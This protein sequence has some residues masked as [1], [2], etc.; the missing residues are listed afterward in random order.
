MLKIV[1]ALIAQCDKSPSLKV[2]RSE[3]EQL[4]RALIRDPVAADQA[5]RD[6]VLSIRPALRDKLPDP[7]V[8][9]PVPPAPSDGPHPG[10]ARLR[11]A[12]NLAQIPAEDVAKSN[13]PIPV[14]GGLPPVS[15]GPPLPDGKQ[16]PR[17]GAGQAKPPPQPVT[18][19][20]AAA[21]RP[22]GDTYLS[23][24]L[25]KMI[26]PDM[27]AA[28]AEQTGP[29]GDACT[30][31]N[32][33][34][35]SAS[36]QGVASAV[37]DAVMTYLRAKNSN[38]KPGR[39]G[40][41]DAKLVPALPEVAQAALNDILRKRAEAE[42]WAEFVPGAIPSVRE[43]LE[44]Q[45]AFK[46]RPAAPPNPDLMA[47]R[48]SDIGTA[49]LDKNKP[50]EA[51]MSPEAVAKSNRQLEEANSFIRFEII[52]KPGDDGKVRVKPVFADRPVRASAHGEDHVTIKRINAGRQEEGGGADFLSWADCHR[53]AQLIMGSEDQPGGVDDSER[54]VVGT[55][56]GKRA[57]QPLPRGAVQHIRK[58]KDS[59]AARALYG[60]LDACLP[61]F[62]GA[63]LAGKP[64]PGPAEQKV[65]D[66]LALADTVQQLKIEFDILNSRFTQIWKVVR[67]NKDLDA[68]I[69]DG[70]ETRMSK[71]VAAQVRIY[72]NVF[73]DDADYDAADV[74]RASAAI[75][76]LKRLVTLMEAESGLVFAG[77]DAPTV[78]VP[79]DMR[80][81]YMAI[82]EDPALMDAL[83]RELGLNQ[84]ARPAV[85]DAMCQLNDDIRKE[86]AEDEGRD[87]WNY[88]WAGVVMVND[89]GS[90]MAL[91]N[92]SVEDQRAVNEDWYFAL[93]R[94]DGDGSFHAVNC[95]D[96]HVV[97]N[98]T[99]MV[100]KRV[101]T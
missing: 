83:S 23:G 36:V 44:S 4:R 12:L 6:L 39:T 48:S 55:G 57:L 20:G 74:A 51:F 52:G 59:G 54:I 7:P 79:K 58:G 65:L 38:K 98:A 84:Y 76:E 50:K 66:E 53:T 37:Y 95:H 9:P 2:Y 68:G 8:R 32:Y 47:A 28:P 97:A 13:T 17:V 64:D 30:R 94:P 19:A 96:D 100:M 5:A 34:I 3:L 77:R 45:V 71:G 1:E 41:V 15:G 90:F 62:V 91:E 72:D 99:T 29:L 81:T 56:D 73:K 27:F 101:D 24:P 40:D 78:P 43:I 86:E 26:A 22:P 60:M 92:L 75:D 80:K 87:I 42:G 25:K 70:L 14:P 21:P 10:I 16:P 88:H 61:G 46:P 49:R 63:R 33:V 31:Y 69:K 35:H 89:D 85:G 82:A 18:G 93:Y 11:S 67:E